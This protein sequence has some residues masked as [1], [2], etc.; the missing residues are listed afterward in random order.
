MN[1]PDGESRL[2]SRTFAREL[3]RVYREQSEEAL[4]ERRTFY[5]SI[6]ILGAGY[7]VQAAL[8][9]NQWIAQ[10]AAHG[11][12]IVE[13]RAGP[14][15][16][17]L[18]MFERDLIPRW[19]HLRWRLDGATLSWRA[20]LSQMARRALEVLEAEPDL[21][22]ALDDPRGET[23]YSRLVANLMCTHHFP[24]LAPLLRDAFAQ[25]VWGRANFDDDVP[26]LTHARSSA[27]RSVVESGRLD[28]L[29]EADALRMV[30]EMKVDMPATLEQLGRYRT[31]LTE[32]DLAPEVR[33]VLVLLAPRSKWVEGAE[34]VAVLLDYKDLMRSW[35]PVVSESRS[36]E[37]GIAAAV[38]KSIALHLC[39]LAG[40]GGFDNWGLS[41][42]RR[43]LAFIQE[44]S[45]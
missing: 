31:W 34:N 27:E 37:R 20:N 17:A 38:L 36:G 22:S 35:L 30:I 40:P 44:L 23:T 2:A 16:L 25:L 12:D 10:F 33:R 8:P 42:R 5:A 26:D 19:Q 45:P 39:G 7:M 13:T 28:V 15:Q 1:V 14:R 3:G 6:A 4:R 41:R 9:R 11:R 21:A 32:L 24:A 43:T 18:A 29:I